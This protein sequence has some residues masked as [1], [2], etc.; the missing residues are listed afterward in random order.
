[1]EILNNFLGEVELF[2]PLFILVPHKIFSAGINIILTIIF[3][4]NFRPDNFS[5]Y[6]I[7]LISL[8]ISFLSFLTYRIQSQISQ[9]LNQ[10]RRQEN[11]AMEKYLEKQIE[12]QKVKKLI[13]SNFQKTRQS[14][15]KKTLSYLPTFIIPGLSILFCFLYS[16]H[17]N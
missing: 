11:T 16:M 7:L 14:F 4:G 9:K 15:L 2:T 12:S 8:I 13:K 5:N 6:F 1:M 3:L 10:F 17:E